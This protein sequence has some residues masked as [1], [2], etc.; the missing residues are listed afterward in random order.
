M[1]LDDLGGVGDVDRRAIKTNLEVQAAEGKPMK[2]GIS[3]VLG[4]AGWPLRRVLVC[5]RGRREGHP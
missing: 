1:S 5:S 3:L 2:A 4:D